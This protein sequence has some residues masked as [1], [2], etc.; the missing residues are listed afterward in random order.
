MSHPPPSPRADA[1]RPFDD[2]ADRAERVA[3]P[4]AGH[5]AERGA[6]AEAMSERARL[7]EA[8]ELRLRQLLEAISD[9]IIALDGDDRFIYANARAE[10]LLHVSR[11]TL[12]GTHVRDVFPDLPPVMWERHE[13]ARRTNQG[14]SYEAW[15]PHLGRWFEFRSYPTPAHY[16]LYFRD[17]TER[18]AQDDA[19]RASEERYRLIGLATSDLMYDWD[20]GAGAVYFTD[21]IHTRLGHAREDVRPT[22]EWWSSQI[23]PDDIDRTSAS[24]EEAMHGGAEHWEAEYRFRRGD[25]TWALMLD[26]GSFVRDAGGLATRMVGAMQD[27][28]ERRRIEEQLVQAQKMEVVGRLTGGIAH[29]FNNLLTAIFGYVDLAAD[30]LPP[31]HPAALDLVEVR[32]AAEHAAALTRQLLAFSRKRAAHVRPLRLDEVVDESRRLLARLLGESIHLEVSSDPALWAVELDRGH[33]EQVVMNLAVNARDAMPN[34]GVIAIEAANVV[35]RA[36]LPVA[37]GATLPPGEY[38]RLVVRDAGEGMDA[39]TRAHAFEPFFTTKAGGRGTGLGLATV[40]GIVARAGGGIVLESA[41]G[42]GTTFAI[43]LPRTDESAASALA[44][45]DVPGGSETVLL[46]EDERAVRASARRMLERRGYRVVTA[47]HGGDALDVLRAGEPRIDV[48]VT[49]LRMP[50]LDGTALLAA[51]DVERPRLPVVV[52]SG[53]AEADGPLPPGAPGR[54]LAF[55]EKPFAADVLLRTLR[56]VLG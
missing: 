31:G 11:H 34:G 24:L 3:P 54:P 18:R 6:G 23:H 41:I 22:L 13:L 2:P 50:E 20:V 1:P 43:H 39:E 8:T 9:G 33:A 35:L 15:L 5:D 17:V 26:R 47:R 49:D 51:L 56:H 14:Q 42:L 48:V 28:T 52:V 10:A 4:P 44:L 32:R 7:A 36:P 38:V 21:S 29:D 53:Y 25:G 12:L 46:V 19:L 27:V 16:V 45:E 40:H 55:L 37:T 30:A